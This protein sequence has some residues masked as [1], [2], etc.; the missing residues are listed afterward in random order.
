M[1]S[2][3]RVLERAGPPG[4]PARLN[5]AIDAA[6][7]ALF[8]R[9]DADDIAY[10]ERFALQVKFLRSCLEVSLLGT[11]MTIFD[12]TGV[13]R[14]QRVAPAKHEEICALS[15]VVFPLYHPTWMGRIEWFRRHRYDETALRSED[16]SLLHRT[17]RESQFANL[18][19][20]LLGY[21]EARLPLMA[22]LKGRAN[23]V[24]GIAARSLGEGRPIA[25]LTSIAGHAARGTIDVVGQAV[26]PEGV[27]RLRAKPLSPEQRAHWQVV[28]D[29]V[30][31]LAGSGVAAR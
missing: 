13:A 21:R 22:T 2:R 27:L 8:A 15:S 6:R 12:D 5:Q 7:G 20:P 26:W 18:P 9:M 25:A 19:E 3:V 30:N 14:G 16:Q 24:R 29:L 28:W 10:P 17:F 4:L 23:F 1:D 31:E 11:G